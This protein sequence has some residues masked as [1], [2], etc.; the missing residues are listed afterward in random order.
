MV[1]V[2]FDRYPNLSGI[3]AQRLPPL[4]PEIRFAH[5]S[6]ALPSS[7]IIQLQLNRISRNIPCFDALITPCRRLFIT[8]QK[9][10]SEVPPFNLTMI[11]LVRTEGLSE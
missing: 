8:L 6:L 3:L 5:R 2:L 10:A 4:I 11:L 7:V 9:K 1:T